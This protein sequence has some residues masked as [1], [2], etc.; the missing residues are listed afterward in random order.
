MAAEN[1]IYVNNDLE[2]TLDIDPND[3][4]TDISTA[5]VSR[6]YYKKPDGTTGYWAAT[7][8]GTT[9][10]VYDIPDTDLDTEGTWTFYAYVQYPAGTIYQGDP[11]QREIR[12][13]W[14]TK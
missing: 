3:T 8:S 7:I 10:L 13:T 12:R 1:N 4:G 11:V 5:S 14:Q 2:L 9:D 6:I